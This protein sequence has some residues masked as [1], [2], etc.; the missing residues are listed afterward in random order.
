[1]E[2]QQAKKPSIASMLSQVGQCVVANSSSMVSFEVQGRSFDYN[3]DQH[4]FTEHIF[5]TRKSVTADEVYG[6]VE[7]RCLAAVMA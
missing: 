2:Q 7:N 5:G 1:M 3:T 4:T 6:A